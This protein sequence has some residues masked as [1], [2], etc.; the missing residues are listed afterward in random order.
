MSSPN[1]VPVSFASIFRKW[2][3][4]ALRPASLMASSGSMGGTAGVSGAGDG[5]TGD[6]D[7]RE[8]IRDADDGGRELGLHGGEDDLLLEKLIPEPGVCGR[9]PR[10]HIRLRAAHGQLSDRTVGTFHRL[11]GRTAGAREI[12]RLGH[13]QQRGQRQHLRLQLLFQGSQGGLAFGLDLSR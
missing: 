2:V 7:D 13:L 6:R 1:R 3:Y 8:L 12:E 9:L 5:A 11:N 10:I 4:I